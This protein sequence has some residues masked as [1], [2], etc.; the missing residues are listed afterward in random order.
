MH[1]LMKQR[2]VTILC[3]L[4]HLCNLNSTMFSV[5]HKEMKSWC[6]FTPACRVLQAT[7]LEQFV[8]TLWRRK[9]QKLH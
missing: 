8:S 3:A 6:V 4:L 2:T 5:S 1:G 9:E 7:V